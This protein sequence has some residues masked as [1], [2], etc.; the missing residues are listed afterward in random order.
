MTTA[1][2]KKYA[3]ELTCR[4]RRG[5]RAFLAVLVCSWLVACTDAKDGTGGDGGTGTEDGLKT[6]RIAVVPK[7]TS[8]VFWK[9]VHAGALEGAREAEKEF[10]TKVEIRW[11]GPLVEDEREA[12]RQVIEGFIGSNVDGIVFAPIDNHAMVAPVNAAVGAGKPVVIIDSGLNGDNYVSFVATDNYQGGVLGGEELGKLLGGKGKALLL[13]YQ[14][15]SA[16]TTKR[17]QG[18]ID[19]MR[20]KF[21]D[22]ELLPP[23]LE[24]Y[25]GATTGQAQNASET[26]L[27]TYPD[28][29]GIFCPNES[30]CSGMLAALVKTGRAGSIK[31]VG[32]D[33]SEGLVEGLGKR[34][35]DGLILQSPVRMGRLGVR[36]LID[37][38]EGKTVEKRIDTGV[39]LITGENMD[40]PE[41]QALLSPDLSILDE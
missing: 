21:P 34:H 33:S 4:G 36:S 27:N 2:R 17:E 23:G 18:F 32:F 38:L 31:F 22:I 8:H 5:A 9:S 14:V 16:S 10:G 15:G 24:Q 11:Q 41:F 28:I 29:D 12:Q 19:T 35:L 20:S 7:G 25:A 37:H 26:L 30:S 13:R 1:E 6:Y 3:R 39:F 40:T